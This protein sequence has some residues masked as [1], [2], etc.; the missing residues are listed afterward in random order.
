M[1]VSLTLL[2]HICLIS[3]VEISCI[4]D[5]CIFVV[6]CFPNDYFLVLVTV[7]VVPDYTCLVYCFFYCIQL[8]S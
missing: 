5:V 6:N 1:T 7:F 3:F 2:F 4:V 8:F